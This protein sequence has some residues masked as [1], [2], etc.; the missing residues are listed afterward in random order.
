MAN[1]TILLVEDDP[2][3]ERLALAAFRQS[4]M[5]DCVVVARDG[6]EAVDYLFAQGIHKDR[7]I[8]DIPRVV[9]LDIKLPKLNGIEVLRR[10]RGHEST[11]LVPV[12]LLTSSDEQRDKEEGYRSGANSF[13]RKPHDFDQFIADINELGNYW[14]ELN[15]SPYE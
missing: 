6:Q 5:G 4:G 13:V 3:E 12:V 14:L 2:D 9:F 8:N 7:N 10:I 15:H 1:Q 11:S